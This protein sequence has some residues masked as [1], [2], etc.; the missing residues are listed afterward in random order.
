MGLPRELR[1]KDG[2]LFQTP[3]TGIE[4]LRDGEAPADGTLPAACEILVDIDPARQAEDFDLNLYT[5][6]DGSGGLRLHYDAASRTCTVDKTGLNKRFNMAVGEV[7]DMPLENPLRNLR[8]FV[9]HSSTEYFV[10]DGE[11]TFTTHSYPE[12]EE[13]HYTVSDGA[14]IK[15][16][17][18]KPSVKDDFVI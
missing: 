5:K 6:A 11:A 14:A 15:I 2:K 7:L 1:V 4:K 12:A 16:Y 13:F 17:R 10:N 3:I 18:M 8:I 9:D